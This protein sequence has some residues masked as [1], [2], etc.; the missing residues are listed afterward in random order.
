[1]PRVN[2]TTPSPIRVALLFAQN[3]ANATLS[4]QHGWPRA[5]AESPLFDAVPFNFAGRSLGARLA[6]VA[7]IAISRVDA[8]VLLHSMYSNQNELRGPLARLLGL[9]PQPKAFFIGNEYKAMPEKMRFCRVLGISLLIS[10]CNA[11]SVLA[12][13]RNE[14]GCA[15]E[16][17]PN[18]GVDAAIFSST[19]SLPERPIDIGYRSYEA[20]WYVGNREKTEIADFFLAAA[21]RYNLK[22]DISV[23]PKQRFDSKGYARFLNACRSHIGTESGGDYFELTD[24]TR[25]KVNAYQNANP[26]ASWPEVRRL[27]FDNYGPS[28]PLRIISGRQVEA[29]ACKTVQILFDG[30]Y[31][32]Y[33]QPD[34]HYIP[35]RKDFSNDDEVVRK[36]R[37]DALCA[38]MVDAAYDVVQREF[39]Y[40]RL[41]DKFAASL[42]TIL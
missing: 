2:A 39:T 30:H 32:G 12:L 37:D 8:I 18:T 4:Y 19:A 25:S 7:K 3:D 41:T 35:L 16:S 6:M 23:D 33:L 31:G 9:L 27:F 28:M 40:E 15:V 34:I 10:Q 21:P 1:V 14:L 20:P 5:F 26:Q 36:L 22:V 29:A 42:R 11:P 38:A 17:V 24:A 13:Y